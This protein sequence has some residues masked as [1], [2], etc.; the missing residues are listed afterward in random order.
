MHR[1]HRSGSAADLNSKDGGQLPPLRW[2]YQTVRPRTAEKGCFINLRRFCRTKDRT[3]IGI[4]K[5]CFFFGRCRCMAFEGYYGV[6][7]GSVMKYSFMIA[8]EHLGVVFK[9]CFDLSKVHFM[10]TSDCVLNF[11]TKVSQFN[12]SC[13]CLIFSVVSQSGIFLAY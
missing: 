12:L 13:R 2:R 9:R 4:E 7:R 3:E 1:W 6:Y 5:F 8:P 10:F 11:L